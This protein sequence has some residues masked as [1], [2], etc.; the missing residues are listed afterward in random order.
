MRKLRAGIVGGGQGA[1]IGAVHRI[2]AELDN[3]AR[4]VAGAMSSD[5][6]KAKASAEAWHL[7]RSYDSYETMAAEE[8]K[9]EDGI[10]FVIVATPNNLHL[11][12]ARA[13][14]EAGI[15][16]VCDKPL[17]SS[18]A[19]AL[20]LGEIVAESGRL[21]ALTHT[22]SGYPMVREAREFVASGRL[23]DLRKVQVE[24]NQ[25]W[26][27][28]PLEREGNKQAAWRTDP[29][30]SG[31]SCCVGDIG[32]H[33]KHLVEFV[34]GRKVQSVC[35]E[36]TSFVEGRQLDDDA[37]MLLRLEGGAR[38]TLVCS[39]IACGEENG[40]NI[41]LYGSKAGIEWHQMEPNTLQVKPA[42][43]SWER[44][45]TG[46]G[47]LGEAAARAAR[48][49]AGH[50]EGYLEAFANIYRDFMADVRRVAAG[51]AALCDYPGIEDGIRGMRFVQAAVE[52]SER[53]A[54][55]VEI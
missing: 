40:L 6:E 18:L 4:V 37:S 22:Y 3:E 17:A 20:E 50:P 52:S 46:A 38:G 28:E 33:A 44:F 41:R 19:D 26:L 25:D 49:P 15:H 32:T 10:D 8:A 48:T 47:Y 27:M 36:L 16:V 23:G 45:R 55:W 30:R 43:K 11:P 29:A 31:I 9:I 1:F 34:T 5:P 12:V 2:A 21:F 7:D 54:S 53:E 13:F 14:L 51:E 24:Y 35:A 42:G 39:Q